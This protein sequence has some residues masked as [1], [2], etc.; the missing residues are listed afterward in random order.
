MKIGFLTKN[1]KSLQESIKWEVGEKGQYVNR[2]YSINDIP[3]WV[4]CGTI[5]ATLPEKGDSI[6]R[7]R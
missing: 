6:G 1:F 3:S 7:A 4:K 2:T 5:L